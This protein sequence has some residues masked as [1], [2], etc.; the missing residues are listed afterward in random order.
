MENR[1][2]I[3]KL[4]EYFTQGP[5]SQEGKAA[6]VNF[7][8]LVGQFDETSSEFEVRIAQFTDWYLFTRPISPFSIPPMQISLKESGFPLKPEWETTYKGLTSSHHSLFEFLKLKKGEAHIR[9]IFSGHKLRVTTKNSP[10]VNGF[11]K[12]GIFESRVIPIGTS[13]VF[14]DAYCFHPLL[15]ARYILN[16]VKKVSSLK[17]SERDSAKAKLI[18]TLFRMYSRLEYYKHLPP[19]EIYTD[20]FITQLDQRFLSKDTPNLRGD[21]LL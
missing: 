3:E 16:C 13:F 12:G 4:M 8:N 14:S 15:A 21:E 6:K 17:E 19:E 2:L 11:H 9:D 20:R 18:L 5:F 1:S 7:T 10:I